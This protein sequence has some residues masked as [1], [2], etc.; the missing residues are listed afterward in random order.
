[1]YV[2][3]IYSESFIKLKN[4]NLSAQYVSSTK[5]VVSNACLKINLLSASSTYGTVTE[6]FGTL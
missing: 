2:F 1:M 4:S 5:A 3:G 6:F